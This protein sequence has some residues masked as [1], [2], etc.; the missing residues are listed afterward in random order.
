M[1][2]PSSGDL[3]FAQI[4]AEFGGSDSFADYYRGGPYVP[5]IPANATISTTIEGLAFSQF[6]GASKLS[7]VNVDPSTVDVYAARSTSST[8][9]RTATLTFSGASSYT[10][11]W[12]AG[13]ANISVT[14]TGNSR[15]LSASAGSGTVTIVRSGTL[16]VY[17][18]ANNAIY[19]DVP[20]SFTFEGSL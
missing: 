5:N 14:G 9:T 12:V 1:P 2:L 20:V 10:T 11:A 7:G 18:A 8:V 6:Y 3:S 13:G 19:K 15:T 4:K 16:R 17:D